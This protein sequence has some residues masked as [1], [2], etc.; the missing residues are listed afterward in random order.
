MIFQQLQL[1]DGL[2]GQRQ[3][4]GSQ[5][6][7]LRDLRDWGPW[8]RLACGFRRFRRF[9]RALGQVLG[10]TD[11]RSV[12]LYGSGDFHHVT[13]ALLRRIAQPF[14]LLILDNHP[15][16]MGRLP[17]LHCGTWLHHAA[18]LPNLRRIYHAGGDVDFD[19]GFRRLA[20]RRLL[21][22]GKIVVF[23]AI[24]R[25]QVSFW[26]QVPHQPLRACPSSPLT[27]ERIATLLTPIEEN[28]K[29]FPL[30]VSVDK[31]VLRVEDAVVNWDSGH[32]TLDE[33]G[34]VLRAFVRM[35]GGNLAGADILGDWS[36]VKLRGVLPRI[37]HW[38]EHPRLDVN[39]VEAAKRNEVA[40]L[41]LLEALSISA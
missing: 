2:T 19:N 3:I 13:L 10:M 36:P 31:D 26:R 17:F 30:Y 1:D 37:M 22:S 27:E 29:S 35:A 12:T 38:T 24:R 41:A 5:A 14:N 40:N 7:I 34:T 21:L 32:L 4:A 16:W 39:P 20:P 6:F 8:I 11:D 9:E 33:A 15:D 18:Q 28:L 23:P 25:F